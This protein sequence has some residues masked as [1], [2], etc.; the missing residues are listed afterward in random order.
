[1]TDLVSSELTGRTEEVECAQKGPPEDQA[2]LLYN[3]RAARPAMNAPRLAPFRT[4]LLVTCSGLVLAAGTVV[5]AV[6]TIGIVTAPGVETGM[7]VPETTIWLDP[8]GTEVVK[9]EVI[10]A[11]EVISV[12]EVTSGVVV[13]V[14]LFCTWVVVV[15][16]T[17]GGGMVE[18]GIDVVLVFGGTVVVSFCDCDCVVTGLVWGV[19]VVTGL[20]G[21]VVLTSWPQP[22]PCP[23]PQP[24][25]ALAVVIAASARAATSAYTFF[26]VKESCCRVMRIKISICLRD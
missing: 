25:W 14:V 1:M 8:G 24:A 18:D 13:V 15:E 12:E 23:S 10:V 4:P 7:V 9:R 6:E 16:L 5:R 21:M 11:K 22:A 20:M 2:S 19:V 3:R 17:V 26:M